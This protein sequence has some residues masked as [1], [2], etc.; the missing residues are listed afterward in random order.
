MCV[1]LLLS[2]MYTHTQL[3]KHYDHW[4][5]S[6]T[7]A[8]SQW[9]YQFATVKF[10]QG[11]LKIQK[12]NARGTAYGAGALPNSKITCMFKF[13]TALFEPIYIRHHSAFR[14]QNSVI[15]VGLVTRLVTIMEWGWYPII[16]VIPGDRKITGSILLSGCELAICCSWNENGLN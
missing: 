14:N 8:L 13:S 4:F 10:K 9:P 7:S 6:V 11:T 2:D 5:V 15:G 12:N 3:N 16:A 1:F